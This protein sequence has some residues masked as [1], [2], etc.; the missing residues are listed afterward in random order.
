MRNAGRG[1]RTC[2][3]AIVSRELG[4]PAVVGAESALQR[5]A[6]GQEVTVSCAEGAVGH[7]YPGLLEVK[8]ERTALGELP[9]PRTRILLNIA[10]P[11]W[12]SPTSSS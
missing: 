1:G 5:L 8:V 3:A 12:A 11:D 9:R 4:I 10:D 6:G 7:V 2:H